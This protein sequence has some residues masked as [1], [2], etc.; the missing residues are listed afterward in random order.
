MVRNE[1]RRILRAVDEVKITEMIKGATKPI[2]MRHEKWLSDNPNPKY[3][4][5]A[6]E[7]AAK[8]L[9]SDVGG[10]RE[11]KSLFRSSAAGSCA[12]K[13]VFSAQGI[14]GR[15]TIDSDLAN[16]F[17]TGNFLHLKWQMAGLTEG[18]LAVAELPVESKEY[19]FGGTLDGVI[20]DGSLFEFKSI[21]PRGFSQ[22]CEWGPRHDHILQAHGYMWLANL[23]AVSFVYEDK[24]SGEW[25]EFRVQRDELIIDA[26]IGMVD[27]MENHLAKETLPAPLPDCVKKNGY[28]YRHCPFNETCLSK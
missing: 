11:R 25:R 5:K 16:I 27:D 14:K 19:S 20:D 12:R 7:F 23:P 6:L 17:A 4:K 9:K 24:G 13:Q 28:V 8:V 10:N 26:V 1:M 21:N 3:S 18:W 2:T 15:N 22:V